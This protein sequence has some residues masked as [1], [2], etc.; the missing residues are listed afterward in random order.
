MDAFLKLN[1]EDILQEV[2]DQIEKP[3]RDR[4]ANAVFTWFVRDCRKK[5]VADL[6]NRLNKMKDNILR[7]C[8][9][10]TFKAKGAK[11][12]VSVVGSAEST[13]QQLAY[14]S[15]WFDGHPR[16]ADFIVQELFRAEP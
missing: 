8:E 9:D 15:D 5:S 10:M 3:D 11:L 2:L 16:L 13:F 1:P 14:G 6:P 4:V 7:M 12:E